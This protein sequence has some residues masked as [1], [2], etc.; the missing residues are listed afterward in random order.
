MNLTN[1]STALR[2]I[3]ASLAAMGAIALAG[4]TEK[5]DGSAGCPI[6]CNEQSAV[7]QTVTL[8]AIARDTS[9][10]GGLGKGTETLMLLA[11]RG[12][13]LDTRV[14]IRFDTLPQTQVTSATDGSEVPITEVD[15]A[16]LLVTVDSAAAALTVPATISVYDVDSPGAVDD[17]SATAL[18]ALFTPARLITQATYAA[19]AFVDTLRI[20]LPNS[21]ILAKAQAKA[22]LRLGLRVSASV[23]VSARVRAV[24]SGIPS[25]LRFRTSADT[26][27]APKLLSPHSATPTTNVSIANNLSDFTIVVRGTPPPPAGLLT[28]GGLPGTRAY[29][30]FNIP[31]SIIDSSLVV[32]ATLL[33]TQAASNSP[34][35]ADTMLVQP[36]I[37]L[38]GAA[39]SDPLKASQIVASQ[40]LVAFNRLKTLPGQSG[41]RE[42]EVAPAF[43]V[44]P[45]QNETDL[46]RAIVLQSSQE[47]YSP[48]Q[49]LFYSTAAADPTLRPKLRISYTPRARIG[50]P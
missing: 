6:T 18:A 4:C 12:D 21:F 13:T 33:L 8:D 32:R 28:V 50:V 35:P 40:S 49:V 36:Y 19:G 38:A 17:T 5:L 34:D 27:V 7:I 46:P 3:V 15:S 1:R 25:G 47:D 41:V 39:V 42:V 23:S 16:A 43:R 9:V 37:I 10:L 14:I 29:F 26:A 31:P 24:E 44:W 11:N 48:Q 30:L 45:A 2:T 20:P 22:R